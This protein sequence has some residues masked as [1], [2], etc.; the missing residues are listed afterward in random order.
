MRRAVPFLAYVLCTGLLSGCG[1][2]ISVEK[3]VGLDV[4]EV[5][6]P[7]VLDGPK[8]DQKIRVDFVSTDATL[9]ARIV[10][11]KDEKAIAAALQNPMPAGL[12]IKAEA[13]NVKDGTLEATIPSG[14]DYGV[15]LSGAAK[16]TSVVVKL[17]SQ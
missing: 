11:G 13:K 3:T 4:G 1:Q 9:T 12:D 5:Q 6:A 10:I 2:R 16:K 7:I 15:Y 17:K 8:S 14:K